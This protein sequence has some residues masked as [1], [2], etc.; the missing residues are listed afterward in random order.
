[1]FL[2]GWF[3]DHLQQTSAD[4][5][6]WNHR[7]LIV[8]QNKT[9]KGGPWGLLGLLKFKNPGKATTVQF[10]RTE[11]FE[12][13]WLTFKRTP[14]AHPTPHPVSEKQDTQKAQGGGHRKQRCPKRLRGSV[15]QSI[16][17]ASSGHPSGIGETSWDSRPGWGSH[18]TAAIL[19][20]DSVHIHTH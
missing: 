17:P 12:K 6:Y 15:K 19:T 5:V 9:S 13:D 10:C 14:P 4:G 1:M 2:Q 8:V 11:A 20:R 18:V 16:R 7:F 3:L